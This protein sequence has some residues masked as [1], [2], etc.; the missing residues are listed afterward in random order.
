MFHGTRV[1]RT[2]REDLSSLHQTVKRKLPTSITVL[3]QKYI[4]KRVADLADKDGIDGYVEAST[5]TIGLDSE[6]VGQLLFKTF[7]HEVG[8]A[9]ALESGLGESLSADALEMFCQS[10]SSFILN[11]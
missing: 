9:F 10:F 1:H 4:I 2:S 3:T 7:W 11:A 5:F 8:H 6:L